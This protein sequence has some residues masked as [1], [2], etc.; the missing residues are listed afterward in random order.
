ML[1]IFRSRRHSLNSSVHHH[2]LP[3]AIAP[4]DL[5]LRPI[6]EINEIQAFLPLGEALL[7]HRRIGVLLQRVPGRHK[8]RKENTLMRRLNNRVADG[9]ERLSDEKQSHV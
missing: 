5:S 4:D 8:V 7:V 1:S 2:L 3:R 9:A 6:E